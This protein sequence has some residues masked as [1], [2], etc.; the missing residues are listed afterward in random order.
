V[1]VM[2]FLGDIPSPA[3]IGALSDRS[4]LER[5]ILIV[6]VAMLISGLIWSYAAY[7]AGNAVILS[8]GDGEGSPHA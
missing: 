4:S 8:R 2:H 7:T 3:M 6:T 1:F 5:G